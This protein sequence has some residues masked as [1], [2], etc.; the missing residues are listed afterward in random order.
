MLPFRKRERETGLNIG[1][2][3]E[4][5]DRFFLIYIHI[6]VYIYIFIKICAVI[7]PLHARFGL[8]YYCLK[9]SSTAAQRNKELF[10]IFKWTYF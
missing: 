7:G 5:G 2:E 8:I 3:R 10:P 1:T 6:D 9:I 4:R